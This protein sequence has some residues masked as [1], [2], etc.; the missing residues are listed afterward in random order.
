MP[1]AQSGDCV[2]PPAGA[3]TPGGGWK[4]GEGGAVSWGGGAVDAG[5]VD[6]FLAAALTRV[7]RAK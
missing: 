6:A 7:M 2:L 4:G 5:Y 1:S 3:R